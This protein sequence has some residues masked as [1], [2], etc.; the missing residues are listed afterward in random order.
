MINAVLGKKVTR[1]ITRKH[2]ILMFLLLS[3]ISGVNPV[4]FSKLIDHQLLGGYYGNFPYSGKRV[5]SHPF[6][7]ILY[8]RSCASLIHKRTALFY[9]FSFMS[10]PSP[11]EASIRTFLADFLAID[12]LTTQS[13]QKVLLHASDSGMAHTFWLNDV[14]LASQSIYR[15]WHFPPFSAISLSDPN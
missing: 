7:V 1:I 15:V 9:W 10:T 5:P 13:D 14:I 2:V 8:R 12:D 4:S 3:V 6:G 11:S